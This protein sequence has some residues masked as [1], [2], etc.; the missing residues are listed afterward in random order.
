MGFR[1]RKSFKILPGLKINISNGN[2][3]TTFGGKFGRVNISKRGTSVG[4]SIPNTGISYNKRISN[5]FNGDVMGIRSVEQI[6]A[7]LLGIFLGAFGLHKFYTGRIGWG[8]I[9]LIFC[10]TGIPAI[11]GIIEGFLYLIQ[12]PEEFRAKYGR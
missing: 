6:I 1:W 7:A 2:L 10:W 12:S 5:R 8:I 3:S 11:L 9:Y 4:S